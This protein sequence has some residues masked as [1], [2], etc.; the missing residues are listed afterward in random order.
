M[1][2]LVGKA[3]A[4]TLKIQADRDRKVA[5]TQMVAFSV[6]CHHCGLS[7]K[8]TAELRRVIGNPAELCCDGIDFTRGV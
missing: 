3:I 6:R 7:R 1:E 8:L 4:E 5:I 2:K